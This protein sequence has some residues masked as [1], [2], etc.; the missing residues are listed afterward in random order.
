MIVL[1]LSNYLIFSALGGTVGDRGTIPLPTRTPK[2]TF[3]PTLV[4]SPTFTFMAITL[5]T[6]TPVPTN[7]PTAVRTH[8][9][10]A[11]ETPSGIAEMYGIAWEALAR[12]NELEAPYIIYAGQ[13]LILP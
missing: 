9:V 4:P 5:P 12:I 3:T 7:T 13:V 8:I 11:G 1:L 10:K 2:P 6:D